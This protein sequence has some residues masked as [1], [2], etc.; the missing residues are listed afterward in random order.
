MKTTVSGALPVHNEEKYLPYMLDSISDACLDELV[1]VLDR[2]KDSSLGIMEKFKE[3]VGYPIKI[4]EIQ[5]G[6]W[7]YS[8]T[9][10][11]K[12]ALSRCTKDIVYP[13]GADCIYNP[14]IFRVDWSLYDIVA[15][16]FV[17]YDVFGQ[18]NKI[19]V[20]WGN[21]YRNLIRRIYPLLKKNVYSG[22]MGIKKHLLNPIL[23]QID[24]FDMFIWNSITHLGWRYKFFPEIMNFH[25]RPKFYE[26]DKQVTQAQ[27]KY[28]YR[29]P[30]WKVLAQSLVNLKPHM[31]QTYLKMKL[32]NYCCD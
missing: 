30:M 13:L 11:F 4:V 23:S 17:D 9:E 26:R 8:S 6:G 7:K 5:E 3:V 21:C 32:Q 16:P 31:M 24:S 14:Q 10:I 20:I 25:L 27:H 22:I 1:V 29:I 28:Q 19:K 18:F 2:C 15:F 12:T